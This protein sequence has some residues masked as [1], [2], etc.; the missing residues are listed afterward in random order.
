[1]GEKL[2]ERKNGFPPNDP[3]EITNLCPA[4]NHPSTNVN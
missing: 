2:R 4:Q 1:M 3:K